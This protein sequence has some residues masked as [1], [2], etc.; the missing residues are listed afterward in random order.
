MEKGVAQVIG[1]ILLVGVG[2]SLTATAYYMYNSMTQEIISGQ[3]R[4]IIGELESANSK[5]RIER[6]GYC[7]VYIRNVGNNNIPVGSLGVYVNNKAVKIS[8]TKKVLKKGEGL[9]INI[10]RD[11]LSGVEADLS[12][13]LE[14]N[15]KDM[16]KITCP[17]LPIP[18]NGILRTTDCLSN[19]TCVIALAG[20]N[21]SH[22]ED[23]SIGDYKYKLCVNNLSD[24]TL[25]SSPCSGEGI[26]TLSGNTNAQVEEYPPTGFATKKNI[27]ATPTSGKLNCIY[28]T[29]ENCLAQHYG[30]LFS[31]SGLTNA[32]AADKDY[33]KKVVCCRIDLQ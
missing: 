22:V 5:I 1:V 11:M 20:P 21:N 23:C 29:K 14:G 3:E 26:I 15:I 10:S 32:H 33:Y 17:L 24:V 27:C 2:V 13:M 12:L 28:N 4:Q 9:E 7:S 8:T 25:S 30:L 6:I 31:I 19:E 16:G 18:V